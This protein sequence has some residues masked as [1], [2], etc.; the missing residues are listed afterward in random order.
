[1]LQ[2]GGAGRL[3][4]CN[5]TTLCSSPELVRPRVFNIMGDE[6]EATALRYRPDIEGLRAL[7]VIPV[8]FFHFGLPGFPGGFVGVD[9]FFVISGYLMARLIGQDLAQRRFS[10]LGFYERR[11]LRLLPALFTVLLVSTIAASLWITPKLFNDFASMLRGT[12]LISSN[13]VLWS[14]SANYFS[15]STDWNPLVHTWS[16]SVEE[17]FYLFFPLLLMLIWRMHQAMRIAMVALI[18]VISLA[19]SIWG[20]AN[21]PTATFYLLP[22]RAWELLIGA[23]AGLVLMPDPAKRSNPGSVPGVVRILACVTG[24]AFIVGSMVLFDRE[25]VFPGAAALVPCT[26]ATLLLA[27]GGEPSNPTT[28]LL[29]ARPIRFIGKISYSLYLWHW[30]LLVIITKYLGTGRSPAAI[31]KLALLAVAI[32]IAYLSWRWI[33]QPFR[34]LGAWAPRIRRVTVFSGTAAGVTAFAAF[35]SMALASNGWPTRFPN[36]GAVSLARQ[37][38]I[39]ASNFDWQ[40]YEDDHH[41]LC[42]SVRATDWQPRDC[43][44]THQGTKNALLWGDSFAA[45]YSSGF[46]TSRH[47]D[48]NVVQ[49]THPSCPPILDY[50]AASRPEC[51]DFDER[52]AGIVRN[53]AITT[54]I[55]AANWSTYLQRHKIQYSDIGKT[56]AFL[57]SLHVQV[58]LVGQSPIFTFAYPDEYFYSRYGSEQQTRDYYAPLDA[59]PD[60]NQHIRRSAGSDIDEF[61]DPLRAWCRAGECVFKSG[62]SYLYEDFGHFSRAGSQQAVAGLLQETGIVTTRS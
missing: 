46:F 25:M 49:Y 7:A 12:V 35:G 62:G 59:D 40:K 23:L 47:A 41:R 33:E 31:L 3:T 60:I 4:G 24:L 37:I 50:S 30:P 38:S 57:K 29:S 51:K 28:R 43:F 15:A 52:V 13:M 26:G 36:I 20:T 8:C 19:V 42:F 58:I 27:F 6:K 17:Q 14:M 39:D 11:A 61:F 53:N 48:L 54:V 2:D 16:L 10:L 34:H 5:N 32:V 9:V 1:M 56:A 22:M 55:M 18:G 45:A 44:L 21:A